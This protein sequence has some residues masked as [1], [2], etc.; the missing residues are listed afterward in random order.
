MMMAKGRQPHREA[1]E[2]RARPLCTR[3][4]SASS[5]SV[6]SFLLFLQAH[7]EDADVFIQLGAPRTPQDTKST[8]RSMLK[9]VLVSRPLKA[10]N[11]LRTQTGVKDTFLH[12]FLEKAR[13]EAQRA[14]QRDPAAIAREVI[15][16]APSQPPFS[17]VWR[18]RGIGASSRRIFYE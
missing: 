2:R 17:P 1:R 15:H 8:L 9:N 11:D 10:N 13:K 5:R 4:S 6:N 16:Q 7:G 18:L 12:Y 3:E 14:P